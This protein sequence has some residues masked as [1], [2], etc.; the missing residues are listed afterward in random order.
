MSV[1]AYIGEI[2]QFCGD[3]APRGG[4]SAWLPCDGRSLSRTDAKYQL[5]FR[6]IGSNF[7]SVDGGHFNIPDLRERAAVGAG[8]GTGLRQRFLGESGGEAGITHTEASMAWHRHAIDEPHP[9]G[10]AIPASTGTAE[11]A[12]APD[13]GHLAAGTFKKGLSSAVT[14]LYKA[15]PS[16]D[17]LIALGSVQGTATAALSE[18]GE[19]APTPA[20]N[21]QPFLAF[22]FY[23]AYTGEL[24]P[25]S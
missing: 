20:E 8:H 7:G 12:T 5:L 19:A 17:S 23:I 18:S 16:P 21:R 10:L 15:D 22:G 13:G 3:F 9:T 11:L 25:I 6:V 4:D 2:M 14:N 1:D 24:P